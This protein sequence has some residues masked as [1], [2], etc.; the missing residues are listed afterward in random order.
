MTST[1]EMSVDAAASLAPTETATHRYTVRG[2]VARGGLGRVLLAD[3][4]RL[5]RPVAVKELIN[6]TVG[7]HERFRREVTITAQLQHPAIVPIYDAG[8][9]ESGQ[10]YYVMKLLSD[11]RTL[12]QAAQEAKK[13]ED[14]L[15]LLPNVIAAADAV[16]YAH[17]HGVIH[18]D[19]KPAN[20]LVGPFGET[21]VID[22]GL[23]KQLGGG[24]EEDVGGGAYR[25]PV[26]P[27]LTSA[28]AVMGTPRY[29]S[30]EQARGEA[31][32]KRA[33]VYSLGAMLYEV[34]TGDAP[35]GGLSASD[36]LSSLRA[37][38]APVL[39]LPAIPRDLAA[40]VCKAMA[41][42]LANR[43]ANAGEL[44]D[45][46]RR[47]Q[48]GQ[49]V[50]AQEYSPATLVWRW[51]QRYRALLATAALAVVGLLIMAAVGIHRIANARDVAEAQR[52]VAVAKRNELILLQ[53]RSSLEHDPT[54]AVA[55]LKTYPSDGVGWPAVQTLA[56]KAAS[57]GVARHVLRTGIARDTAFLPDGRT[58]IAAGIGQ[59]TWWDIAREVKLGS[60]A[61]DAVAI[62]ASPDGRYAAIGGLHGEVVLWDLKTQRLREVA[63]FDSPT[64]GLCFSSDGARLAASAGGDVRVSTIADGTMRRVA[65]GEAVLDQLVFSRDGATLFAAGGAGK[66]VVVSLADGRARVLAGHRGSIAAMS[67]SSDGTTLVTGGADGSVRVWLLPIAHSR[68]LEQ[69]TTRI[70]HV[71][72]VP[73][74]NRVVYLSDDGV[75][76]LSSLRTGLIRRSI[77]QPDQ[78]K[79][80]VVAPDATY[81]ATSDARGHLRTWDLATSEATE[82]RGHE[83]TIDSLAIS[84]DG[85]L[86]SSGM[87]DSTRVW[88]RPTQPSAPVHVER[89]DAAL[90]HV[91]FS[92]DGT[93]VATEGG[94]T[95][96]L[97]PAAT[98]PCRAFNGHTSAI[99]GIA[100]SHDG[101]KLVS[102][103][104]DGTARV[105]DVAS[106]TAQVFQTG[107]TI[108]QRVAF[109]PDERHVVAAGS[110]G[111]V[112][113]WPSDGGR[114]MV[115]RGH[116]GAVLALAASPMRSL[117]ASGG[118]DGTV[119][120]WDWSSGTGHVL[121]RQA[122]SVVLASFAP[123]GTRLA[124]GG[125]DG[126]IKLWNVND[127]SSRVVGRHRDNISTLAFSPDGTRLL[128]SSWDA[129][130]HV[131]AL[132]GRGDRL[133][134][135][136]EQRV[137]MAAWSPGGTMVAT[138][139]DDR[140]VR[141]WNLQTGAVDVFQG[142]TAAVRSVSFSPDGTL[143]AAAGD[144]MTL[145][146]WRARAPSAPRNQTE[147]SAW[148]SE[149]T[150]Q[151]TR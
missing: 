75:L 30:P 32:E 70:T 50:R 142:S 91:A 130:A 92:P 57:L 24:D 151:Q 84:R 34:L 3:D 97:C 88:P 110:D 26:T 7:M 114:R 73:D 11:G 68:V 79:Q 29:M 113:I 90:M 117:V 108:V 46:L 77:A 78:M 125:R 22:W 39:S 103:G 106:G 149:L 60:A 105:W 115:L 47:F 71:E 138:A 65:R 147:L 112:T 137:R 62:K 134:A 93:Q 38:I 6:T 28:G 102:A 61:I 8:V 41:P 9:W 124:T 31:V 49:L 4:E 116:T 33:D 126:E 40:I 133:L 52:A 100:F 131:W 109:T 87:D 1:N 55:W 128:S 27:E 13:P 80:L 15:A 96:H 56:A 35:F 53:A 64:V 141:V 119:R 59:V 81:I 14:H 86:I 120:V 85:T 20:V 19:L 82:L 135:G 12:K 23:A 139:S 94:P 104:W 54:Q 136:H 5:H 150:T 101:R 111:T 122:T 18:R 89:F 17:S 140:T 99:Y 58:F 45:D 98:G 144:D 146:L 121:G 148:L 127:A 118:E 67:L 145:R 129:T 123:D 21:V 74:G 51:V 95:I 143:L 132:D 76:S 48:T 43:Y 107:S 83:A 36:I 44:V 42:D 16:A 66:L 25:T 63:R 69:V 10:P 72:L 2:E 37:S